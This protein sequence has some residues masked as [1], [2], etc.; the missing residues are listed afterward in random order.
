M[1]AEKES[2]VLNDRPADG[3]AKL[4]PEALREKPA[5]G[6]ERN[7]LRERIAWLRQIVATEHERAAMEVVAARLG[8]SGHHACIGLS[9]FRVVVGAGDFG[10]NYRIEVRDDNHIAVHEV[11]VIC[12]VKKIAYPGEMLTV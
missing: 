4:A 8:G 3:S 2:S 12:A 9:K 6:V 5:A 1:V 10:L 7:R 11:P